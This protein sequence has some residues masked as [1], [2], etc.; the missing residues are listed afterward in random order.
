MA[1]IH[2]LA[3]VS[4]DAELGVNTVIGP[5]SVVESGARIGAGCT[6]ASHVVVKSGV[7][8]G[9]ENVIAEGVV[10]GGLPQ[11][12]SPP[13]PPGEVIIGN[14]N[15]FRENVTIHRSLYPG[16]ATVVGNHCFVMVGVHF[17]HDCT[18]GDRVI[19]ANNAILGGHVTVGEKAF[20]SGNVAVHQFCRIGRQSMVGGLARITRDV[21]PFV[22]VDGHTGRVCGLNLI[23][24]RRGGMAA[25]DIVQIKAAYRML[26]RSGLIWAELLKQLQEQFA[27]GPAAELFEFVNSSKRGIIPERRMPTSSVRL[28]IDEDGDA[29]SDDQAYRRAG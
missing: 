22:T 24:L 1:K 12:A 18:I 14:G 13:G 15:V 8:L 4:P 23:G 25:S 28:Q 27:T 7:T 19:F 29:D 10:I 5:F 17:A 26:Y 3:V 2:P 9:E 6:L 20:V 16:K 11:H 21:P